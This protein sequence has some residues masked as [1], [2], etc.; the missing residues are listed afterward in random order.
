MQPVYSPYGLAPSPT[1]TVPILTNK[2]LQV[3]NLIASALGV[4]GT[5]LGNS[6]EGVLAGGG[7]QVLTATSTPCRWAFVF[8]PAG[9]NAMNLFFPGQLNGY[10]VNSG[11]GGFTIPVPGLDLSTVSISGTAGNKYVVVY[12]V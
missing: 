2:M 4:G 7:A 9:Q 1:D 5:G 11:A 10:P 6:I 12:I 3:L 8:V